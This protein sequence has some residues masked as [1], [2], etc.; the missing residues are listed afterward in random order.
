M[1]SNFTQEVII[2][3]IQ[4]LDK[5]NKRI[6]LIKFYENY[7]PLKKEMI[8]RKNYK[9]HLHP[10]PKEFVDESLKWLLT[11]YNLLNKETSETNFT[12]TYLFLFSILENLATRIIDIENPLKHDSM[13]LFE[14]RKDHNKLKLF[15]QEKSGFYVKSDLNLELS[16][17]RI[18][19]SQKIFNT[20]DYLNS[21]L[22]ESVDINVLVKK[23]N[24]II[25]ANT[26]TG[27]KIN[28]SIEDIKNLNDIIINGLSNVV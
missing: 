17:M 15:N 25:H 6:F 7:E 11:S 24:D 4:E 10:L 5:A 12:A 19:W 26:T 16:S 9:K 3:F 13:Y 21:K 2:S 20:V 1:D 23:R 28:I 27:E 22:D 18:P 8:L 14:F